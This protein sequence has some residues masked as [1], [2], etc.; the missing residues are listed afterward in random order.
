MHPALQT[1][2]IGRS[3]APEQSQGQ[4]L[5]SVRK[6]LQQQ[7]DLVRIKILDLNAPDGAGFQWFPPE[8]KKD[9]KVLISIVTESNGILQ[10]YIWSGK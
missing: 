2:V 4:M 7:T 6:L 1:R 10:R 5:I 8:R 3:Q 9:P